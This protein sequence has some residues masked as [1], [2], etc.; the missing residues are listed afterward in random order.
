MPRKKTQSVTESMQ[1]LFTVM[2]TDKKP[3]AYIERELMKQREKLD[4]TDIP[5]AEIVRYC[6][7]KAYKAMGGK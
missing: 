1:I 2:Q 5:D 3:L 6:I 4:C 7:H